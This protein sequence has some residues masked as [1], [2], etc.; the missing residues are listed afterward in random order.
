MNNTQTMQNVKASAASGYRWV[1]LCIAFGVQIFCSLSLYSLSPLGPY[2][3]EGLSISNT[4]FGLLFTASNFGT[5]LML[6]FTGRL[7]DKHGVRSIMLIGQLVMGI[8]VICAS[9]SRSMISLVLILFCTGICQSI[10]GPTGATSI[11]T[12]FSPEE[13]ATAMG[14]KQA[15]IPAAGI[16]AGLILPAVASLFSWRRA[17]FL[18]GIS[19]FLFGILSFLLYRDSDVMA[20]MRK[21]RQNECSGPGLTSILTRDILLISVGCGILMGVQFSFT[22]Y[23]VVYLS[24]V[25]TAMAAAAPVM[26]AGTYYSWTS[27]GGFIGRIGLGLISD[28]LFHGRRK[29]TLLVVCIIGTLILFMMAFLVPKFSIVGIGILVFFYGLTGVS[30]TGIQLS[31]ISEIAGVKASGAAT[32]FT[33]ALGFAGMMIFPP[34]FG[35]I[36][37]TNGYFWGWLLLAFLSLTGVLFILPVREPS[38]DNP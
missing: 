12:W 21:N 23:L 32:G 36:A 5:M 31:L 19:I 20:Y 1:I 15:G 7:V 25:F 22:S 8:L 37:D 30:F 34:L 18:V 14:I 4:Q 2:I 29:G 26:L 11:V 17:L 10:A 24:E 9:M 28:R 33:L 35:S 16:A 6:T 27:S 13:R 3:R 38:H